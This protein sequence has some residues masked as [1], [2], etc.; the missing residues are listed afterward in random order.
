[1]NERKRG[2]R[3]VFPLLCAAVLLAS[4]ACAQ[5]TQVI[6]AD[7]LQNGWADWSWCQDDLANTGTVH[8]GQYSVAVTLN[9]PWAAF[10]LE[11]AAFDSSPYTYLTFWING[12][13]TAGRAIQVAGLLNGKNQKSVR[14]NSYLPAGSVTADAWQQV[15]IPLADL[16]VGR[17]KNFTGFWLQDAEG[18]A[19]PTFYVDD[20]ALTTAPVTDPVTIAVNAASNPHAI[21]PRIYGVAFASAAQLQALNAP[22]NRAGGNA[23]S[24]YN[25]QLNATNHAA[26]WFFE[27]IAD[28]SSVPGATYDS[29]VSSSKAAGAEAILTI[30]M[31][32]WVANLGANRASLSGYS[33]AK[34]GAQ[35]STDPWWADAGNGIL[36]STGQAITTNDPNDADIPADATFQTGWV[37]HLVVTWGPGASGG[38][39]YYAMDNE[40]SIWFS[41]HRDVHP[42]GETMAEE[43]ADILAYGAMVKAADPSAMVLGPEEWGWDGYFYSGFDQQYA[44]AHGWSSFPDRAAHGGWDYIPW[45]LDQLRQQQVATGQRVLDVCTVHFYPQAGEFGNDVSVP[46]QLLRNRSTRQLWDPNYVSESWINDTVNLIPRMKGW[47]SSNY[48]GTLI[49]LTEYNWGAEGAINGAT[50]QADVFGILGREGVDLAT[51]WT[52]PAATTPTFKA[53]QMYRNYDGKRSTFGDTGVDATVPDPDT[54]AAY[55]AVRSSDGALT[56]MVINKSLANAPVTLSLANFAAGAKAHVWQLASRNVINHLKDVAI[57]GDTINLQ[58]PAQSVTLFVVP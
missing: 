51:R 15:V 1:M 19:Q 48:P 52:T 22:L 30:P 25:W 40:P 55:A 4:T 24:R 13:A 11:H 3:G 42:V 34:Y 6:Y 44:P 7:A 29:F 20:I 47:V 17:H 5:T 50:T 2:Y 16:H 58:V 9:A 43:L 46:M 37:Q 28:S 26:D 12:G 53:M 35:T 8:S 23:T 49:G 57:T 38:V 27:S 10:Y 21:D 41:T 18:A 56:V 36:K 14:L 54:V 33:V 32:G 31:V 39:R 45:V